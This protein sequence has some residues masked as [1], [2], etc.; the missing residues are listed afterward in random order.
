[1]AITHGIYRRDPDGTWR[2]PWGAVVPGA[3]DLTVGMLRCLG[4]PTAALDEDAPVDRVVG[5]DAPEL[6]VGAMLTT[7]DVAAL[8]G[9]TPQTIV[10]YRRRGEVPEP[11]AVVGRSPLWARPVVDQWLCTRPGHGWR[12]DLY[13]DRAT[14]DARERRARARRLRVRGRP[15]DRQPIGSSGDV[16]RLARK[17]GRGDGAS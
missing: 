1:M 6:Q 10:A 15:G 7:S 11:Q 13:G 8:A 16:S 17:D 2:Y 14:H 12:T 9:V 5:M 4:D 3:R